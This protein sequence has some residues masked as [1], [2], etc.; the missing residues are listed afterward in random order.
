MVLISVSLIMNDG[1]HL[2]MCLSTIYLCVCIQGFCP[3]FNQTFLVLSCISSLYILDISPLSRHIIYK[4]F[5]TLLGLPFH[6]V[7]DFFSYAKLFF[8]FDVVPKF[9]FAFI[10]FLYGFICLRR[11]IYISMADVKDINY[12]CFLLG[13]FGF[14]SHM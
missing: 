14:M 11:H 7:E 2:F 10:L 3:L 12:Q 8:F 1:E 5:L 6:F 9:I 4:Y 13:V